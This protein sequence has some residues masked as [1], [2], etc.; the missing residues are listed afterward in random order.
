V[1]SRIETPFDRTEARA[2]P[3]REGEVVVQPG[4]SLWKLSQR[5]YGAGLRYT[6]IFEANRDRVR[7]PDLIYPGQVFD[8]PAAAER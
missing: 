1:L 7:D 3:L 2:A 6:V 5:L 4:D 8:I